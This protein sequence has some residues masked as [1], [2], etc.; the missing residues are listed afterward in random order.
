[1][2]LLAL[3]V[4]VKAHAYGHLEAVGA[5]RR[6]RE[7]LVDEL[8]SKLGSLRSLFLLPIVGAAMPLDI[9]APLNSRCPS[10]STKLMFLRFRLV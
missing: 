3:A 10:P 1:M 4:E 9:S 6:G 8:S 7:L 5:E 2:T